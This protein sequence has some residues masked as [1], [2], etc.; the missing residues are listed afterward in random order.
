[1]Q[2]MKILKKPS[3]LYEIVIEKVPSKWYNLDK[4]ER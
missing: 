3:F 2:K 4:I 1:M